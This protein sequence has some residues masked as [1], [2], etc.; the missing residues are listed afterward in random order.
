MAKNKNMDENPDIEVQE[1]EVAQEATV[2]APK[3]K[4]VEVRY[5]ED[6]SSIVANVPYKYH[7]NTTG[8]IPSD[9]AA[10]LVNGG[11]AIKL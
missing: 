8:K 3:T 5:L 10:I 2:N 4:I 6:G 11:V 1:Q 7:K 9:V